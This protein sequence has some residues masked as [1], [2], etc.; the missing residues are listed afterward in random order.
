MG[1]NNTVIRQ[2]LSDKERFASLVNGALFH[3]QEIFKADTL[4][5]E[6]SQQ[7]VLMR[8]ADG[9]NISMERYRDIIMSSHDNTRI[10]LLAC[11]NQ[12]E[13]HYAMPVRT[14]LYDALSYVDQINS[15][16]QHHR[17]EKD[18]QGNAEFLSGLKRE[19]FLTPVITIVFYYGEKPWDGHKDLH[20]LLGIN[21]EEYALLKQY[22]PNYTINLVDPREID[23]LRCF[24][25]NLQRI[26]EMIKYRQ[27]PENLRNYILKHEDFFE[28]MDLETSNAMEVF[29]GAKKIL[30]NVEKNE[31]G[32]INMKNAF[33]MVYDDGVEKGK[34]A[35]LLNL[36]TQKLSLGQSVQQIAD[37]LVDTVDH[38]QELI[39]ILNETKPTA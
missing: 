10:V 15:I 3:G 18:L 17:S 36:I 38:I 32:G 2:W 6:D 31:K 29:V 34:E 25:T 1:K 35:V 8:T 16:K 9:K 12:E 5:M 24:Q 30:K 28:N 14:M 7:G 11:E 37:D 13:I 39:Q 20:S 4:K 19:D 21:R 23:D 26:F 22:I 27:E 33:E